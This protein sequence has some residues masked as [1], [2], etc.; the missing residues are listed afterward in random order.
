MG[1][2]IA[3]KRVHHMAV[4]KVVS[5]AGLLNTGFKYDAHCMQGNHMIG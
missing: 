5:I 3:C 2:K 1:T 4:D